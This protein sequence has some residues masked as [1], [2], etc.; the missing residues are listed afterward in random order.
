MAELNRLVS[1]HAGEKFAG[2][3]AVYKQWKTLGVRV[4]QVCLTLS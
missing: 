4:T 3:T 1:E 2:I